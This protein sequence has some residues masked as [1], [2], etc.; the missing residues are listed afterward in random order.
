MRVFSFF[1]F[2]TLSVKKS[3][4]MNLS[5]GIFGNIRNVRLLSPANRFEGYEPFLLIEMAVLLIS[6]FLC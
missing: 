3:F 6:H 5:I 1:Y 2:W 4:I